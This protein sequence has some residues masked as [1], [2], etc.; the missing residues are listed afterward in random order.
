MTPAS[1]DLD[2]RAALADLTDDQPPVP[3]GRLAAIRRKAGIRRRRQ[4]AAT[5]L[6]A[7]GAVAIATSLAALPRPARSL[8]PSERNVPGWA[9]PWPDHRNGSVPQPVLD[10]A[11]LAWLAEVA[12]PPRGSS[13][14]PAPGSSARQVASLVGPHDVVWYVGQTIDAGTEVVV[15]FEADGPDGAQ[16]VA[17][18]AQASQVMRDQPA[19]SY[20]QSPWTLTVAAAPDPQ[21]PPLAIGIYA[22]PD[23][24]YVNGP[25]PLLGRNWVVLLTA[26]DVRSVTWFAATTSGVR[27][28]T[29]H[30]AAGLAVAYAG[31]LTSQVELTGLS[32]THGFMPLRNVA[33]EVPGAPDSAVPSL[34]LPPPLSVP[35]TRALIA[36]PY[37]GQGS[38]GAQ[39]ASFSPGRGR[40]ALLA[41]CYGA[42]PLRLE[43][44]GHRIGTIACDD[45]QHQLTVPASALGQHGIRLD[46][47]T[48]NMTV[49]RLDLVAVR[50]R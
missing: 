26:P 48:S 27:R 31:P 49:W 4:V 38:A 7:L 21:R 50:S 18:Q 32:T 39:D 34:A 47:D 14:V 45:N 6:A 9:L 40:Y 10:R 42:G 43:V 35:A 17:G 13:T 46:I 44:N 24:R 29:V 33:I 12:G 28:P 36:P 1:N 15:M 19:W 25:I 8:P 5:A 3:P 2:I 16:L 20:A 37:E 41:V 23:S 22:G 30:S 11:V